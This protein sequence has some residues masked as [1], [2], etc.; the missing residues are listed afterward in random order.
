M[1][2]E[3]RCRSGYT[4]KHCQLLLG[5]DKGSQGLEVEYIVLIVLIV[6]S[7]VGLI[8]MLL[9]FRRRGNSQKVI[10]NEIGMAER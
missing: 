2:Y 9:H 5:D 1:D 7:L 8:G 10:I 6:F 4:G 3:C